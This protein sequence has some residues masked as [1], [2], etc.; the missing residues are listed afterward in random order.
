[1]SLAYSINTW[2]AAGIGGINTTPLEPQK[3]VEV[4]V[5]VSRPSRC[6]LGPRDSTWLRRLTG[7]SVSG[8]KDFH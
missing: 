7:I 3:A 6:T 5:R 2:V 1:M 8:S 4:F